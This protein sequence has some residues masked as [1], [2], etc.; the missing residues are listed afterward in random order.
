MILL[1]IVSLAVAPFATIALESTTCGGFFTP[2][3]WPPG[4]IADACAAD[5]TRQGVIGA[6]SA[7]LGL[8]LV[9]GGIV[10]RAVTPRPLGF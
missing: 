2:A 3:P 6:V 8:L 4:P 10:I 1:G 7:L 9:A 5:L